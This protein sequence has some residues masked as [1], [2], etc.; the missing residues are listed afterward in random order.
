MEKKIDAMHKYFGELPDKSCIDC[1][2]LIEGYC[3]N[4]FVRKCTVY[5]AT[6][7]I[8]TD[9]RKK[10]RACG[11]FNKEW[12]GRPIIRIVNSV[13]RK[14]IEMAPLDGQMKMEDL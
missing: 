12:K 5:G 8:A 1:S 2:N 3:G 10:Y 11:M 9:W 13:E 6:H 14:A 7:S 4:T